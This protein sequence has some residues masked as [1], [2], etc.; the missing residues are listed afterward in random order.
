[1][2]WFYFLITSLSGHRSSVPK[3]WIPL[4]QMAR[5]F[6]FIVF[7]PPSDKRPNKFFEGS[8]LPSFLPLPPISSP[9]RPCIAHPSV[10][11]SRG[12]VFLPF[13]PT[14]PF[15]FYPSGFHRPRLFHSSTDF[16]FYNRHC[17]K[18]GFLGDPPGFRNAYLPA[19][20]HK[21]F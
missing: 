19:H 12:C 2:I 13:P 1:M 8:Y 10:Q 3:T 7:N 5:L 16:F 17:F 15:P 14:A 11:L 18:M 21:Y 4:S 6:Q 9:L 20:T